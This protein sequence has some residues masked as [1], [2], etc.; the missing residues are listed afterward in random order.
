MVLLSKRKT[1][2]GFKKIYRKGK[3]NPI[4]K[5]IFYVAKDGTGDFETIDEA[6]AELG[7]DGGTV[8]VKAG[9]YTFG[10]F[11][12]NN[13]ENITLRGDGWNTKITFNDGAYIVSILSCTEITIRDLEIT[14]N[15]SQVTEAPIDIDNSNRVTFQNINWIYNSTNNGDTLFWTSGGRSAGK[16]KIVRCKARVTGTGTCSIFSSLVVDKGLFKD[17]DIEDMD[18]KYAWADAYHTNCIFIGN[19]FKDWAFEAGDNY[20]IVVGNRTDTAII[21]SGTGNEIANNIVY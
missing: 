8:H 11:V 16:L 1:F 12:L 4:N 9:N 2:P 7:T 21:D 19:T 5:P 18:M 15:P 6:I 20:N 14:L 3:S 17:N 13:K 10:G